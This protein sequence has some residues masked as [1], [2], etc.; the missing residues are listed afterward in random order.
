MKT[1][2]RF[3]IQNEMIRRQNWRLPFRKLGRKRADYLAGRML[4]RAKSRP[5]FEWKWSFEMWKLRRVTKIESGG[6]TILA[7]P[8]EDGFLWE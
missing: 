7:H 3:P 2:T 8:T 6:V 5:L 1:A 4:T